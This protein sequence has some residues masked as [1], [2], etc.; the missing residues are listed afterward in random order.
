MPIYEY[1][2]QDCGKITE[3]LVG[4]TQE[5]TEIKCSACGGKNLNKI[6]SPGFISTSGNMLGTQ[7]GKTC[8]G[9][10]ERC[11]SPPCSNNGVCKR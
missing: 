9:K 7:K 10:D 6:I 5:R 8:C 11:D 4:V 3:F 1:R 2:C